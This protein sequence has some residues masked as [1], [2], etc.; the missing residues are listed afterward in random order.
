MVIALLVGKGSIV[1]YY[2]NSVMNKDL[3]SCGICFETSGD[4][5]EG[6]DGEVS[7]ISKTASEKGTDWNMMQH[8]V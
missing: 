1:G 6:D 8:P 5:N 4:H 2:N 3:S 7:E